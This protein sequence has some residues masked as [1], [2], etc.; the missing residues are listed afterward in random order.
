MCKFT[1]V[2]PV[3]N[4]ENVIARAIRSVQA[5]LFED[6]ELIIVDDGSIDETGN[7]VKSFCLINVFSMSGRK[8]EE[9]R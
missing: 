1:V 4:R 8:M 6:W 7:I 3:Y 2:I 5:Q 9:H